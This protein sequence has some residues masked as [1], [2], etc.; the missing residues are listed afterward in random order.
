MTMTSPWLT[1]IQY[2]TPQR[3]SV[4]YGD[5]VLHKTFDLYTPITIVT[6]SSFSPERRYSDITKAFHTGLSVSVAVLEQAHGG[7]EGLQLAP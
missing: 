6:H 4:G 2:K 7:D 5:T 1:M 3:R